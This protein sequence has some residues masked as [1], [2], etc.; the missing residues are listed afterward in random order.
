[1]GQLELEIQRRRE[2]DR[3]FSV[4]GRSFYFF[5]F[6]DNVAFLSTPIFIF[7]K[8]TGKELSL[9]SGEFAKH[10]ATIGK[11]GPYQDY[12]VDFNDEQGS[13]RCFRDV[14]FSRLERLLGKRQ[15]FVEDLA[16]V[17]GYGD[18]QWKGPSW[19]YF[20]YAVFNRRPVSVI[21]ARGHHPDTIRK[22]IRLF[23]DHGYLPA[24]P[25]YLSLYPVSH[26]ETQLAL[27]FGGFA[28]VAEM[29]QAAIRASVLRAFDVYGYSDH[30]RFGVSDDD[31]KNIELITE[32][33][34]KLKR[35]FPEISF[36]VI[37]TCKGEFMKREVFADYTLEKILEPPQQGSLFD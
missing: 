8:S 30:H 13:F 15:A 22:G 3:N 18:F 23:R 20:Y 2:P 33:M 24:E 1:M 29:K 11:L 21:T 28:S 35:E 16:A 6:D 19:L 25:N 36:F 34:T 9:S 31:P 37:K 4:G 10:S 14:E 17:L 27:G 12:R 32:E 5:D 26:P 7:H